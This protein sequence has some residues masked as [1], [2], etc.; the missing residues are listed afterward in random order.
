MCLT[1]PLLSARGVVMVWWL[2]TTW[3]TSSS[4]SIIVR[5]RIRSV[6]VWTVWWVVPLW[7]LPLLPTTGTSSSCDHSATLIRLKSTFHFQTIN[8]TQC[9]QH[10]AN[11]IRYVNKFSSKSRK[12][13]SSI[14]LKSNRAGISCADTGDWL[15]WLMLFSNDILRPN[16]PIPVDTD[17]WALA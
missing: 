13:Y 10:L 12:F 9:V 1:N 16:T 17:D 3:F 11:T 4:I 7:L 2:S 5:D 8:S 6:A 14:Q 15:S